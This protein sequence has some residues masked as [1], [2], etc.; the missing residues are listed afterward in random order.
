MGTTT[1]RHRPWAAFRAWSRPLVVALCDFIANDGP[2]RAGH[3]AFASLLAFFP[4]LIFLTSLAGFLGQGEAAREFVAFVFEMM[5][6]EVANAVAP[7][8]G[9]VVG[10]T[11][12]G[13]LT[14]SLLGSLWAASSGVEALRLAL[15]QAYR[16]TNRRPFWRR[17]L[18]GLAFVVIAAVAILAAMIGIVAGPLIWDL[19]ESVLGVAAPPRWVWGVARYSVASFGLLLTVSLLYRWLP[20]QRQPWRRVLPGAVVAVSAWL[21]A[22]SL[23]SVYFSQAKHFTMTYGSLGGIVIALLFF[24]L[25]AAILIFGAE[26]NAVLDRDDGQGGDDHA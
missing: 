4:F 25:S 12:G 5:P 14:V 18:E 15:N 20:N 17:R 22:A 6:P 3:I 11:R 16:V 1:T 9:E 2:Q 19:V 26:L 24:Y 21:V 8:V 23:A 10:R 13:L 7:A